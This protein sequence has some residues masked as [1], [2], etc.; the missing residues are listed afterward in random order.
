MLRV[1]V[2][3]LV[4]YADQFHAAKGFN[5]SYSQISGNSNEL[6]EYNNTTV[7]EASPFND[8]TIISC[9]A[10]ENIHGQQ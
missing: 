10:T 1:I 9:T 3:I 7:I 2:C 5:I 4:R 8:N 6:E